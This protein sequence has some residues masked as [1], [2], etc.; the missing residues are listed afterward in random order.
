MAKHSLVKQLANELASFAHSIGDE[1]GDTAAQAVTYGALLSRLASG[2]NSTDCV[3]EILDRFDL[4]HL[5]AYYSAQG[6][7]TSVYFYE[8]FLRAYDKANSAKRGIYY[9]PPEVVSC[10][11]RGA[12]DLLLGRFDTSLDDVLILDPCCGIGTF[13]H[14]IETQTD[15]HPQM[16]GL[17]LNPATCS[18]ASCILKHCEVIQADG[19]EDI[20]L[21]LVGR[22]LVVIGNPPYSGHSANS[23][24]IADLLADYRAGLNERNP[25]WLQDDYVKFIRMAQHRVEQAGQGIVAFITNHSFIF[26]PTFRAMRQS[27]MRSFD[28]IYILDLHGNA[29]KLEMCDDEPDENVFPIQ[30][31]VAISFMVKV[32]NEPG[33]RVF[34]SDIKGSKDGKLK[35]LSEMALEKTPWTGIDTGIPHF[36]FTVRDADLQEEFYSFPSVTE[37]FGASSVGFVTSRDSFAID[38]DKDALVNRIA[39]LRDGAVSDDILRNEMGAGDLD[40]ER[41][42]RELQADPDWQRNVVEVLYRPFD[43]RWAYYSRAIME[44]PRL[45]FMENLMQ[46][47]VALAVGR[48][49]HATGSAQWDVV[50]CTDRPADLNL[51]RRG[52]ALLLPR[53]AYMNGAKASNIRIDNVDHDQLFAYIYALLHSTLYRQRYADM[54]SLDFPRIPIPHDDLLLSRLAELGGELI[55]LH[56]MR[57]QA[58]DLHVDQCEGLTIGGYRIPQKFVDDRRNR[59]LSEQEDALFGRIAAVV[60]ATVAVQARIDG[61]VT[62][63]L[64]WKQQ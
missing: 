4:D 35:T 48:A 47:N 30:M 15:F 44:R 3:H 33:C 36:S 22:P 24:K 13:P 56:L 54:L 32:T 1:R 17:E 40:I 12:A 41:A 23:G 2:C 59:G 11:V 10:I 6:R 19:L 28:E 31:G 57:R 38:S 58:D 49:G 62:C 18:L 29:K 9:S 45:P 43:R 42:R 27:L 5:R 21:P 39:A 26:N 60:S 63:S 52:G 16:I 55:D 34:Y 14:F 20:E 46:D 25:K 50:F 64:P 51:F 53:F 7:D 8:E 61:F 37:L